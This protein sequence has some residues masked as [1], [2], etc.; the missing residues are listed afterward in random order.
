MRLILFILLLA[1]TTASAQIDTFT[2]G[3]HH[4]N[5]KAFKPGKTSYAVFFTDTNGKRI[6]SADIWDR[7][8][9]IA[10]GADGSKRFTFQWDWW[11][12]DTLVSQVTAQ[13]SLPAFNMNWHKTRHYTR[14][15]FVYQWKDGVVTIPDSA[16]RTAKDSAFSVT[17]NPLGFEFPMDLELFALIPFK[18]QG[19]EFRMAFYEP[20]SAKSDYYQL[21]VDGKEA[22]ELGGE[23][24]KCWLLTI[25]YRANSYATFWISDE[26]R[27]V[28]KMKE[29]FGR[30]YRYKVR[31]F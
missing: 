4:L 27:E 6:S 9:S 2:T 13:G 5:L 30:G 23:K 21:S 19:Q 20:G 12:K 28:M 18:K 1:A 29:F 7:T 14:G 15:N 31:M 26:T 8:I 22:I 11:R 10:D 24:I 25:H 16:K 17:L 3:N